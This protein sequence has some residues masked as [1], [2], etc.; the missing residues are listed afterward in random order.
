MALHQATDGR[1]YVLGESQYLYSRTDL[2][3]TIVYANKAFV[4]ASG[5]SIDEL[6]GAPHN[7]V[8]HPDMPGI[9]FADFW[10]T[11]RAGRTWV[12]LVKNRRKNGGFYWVRA[13]VSPVFDAGRCIGFAS[14]RVKP[15]I[16]EISQAARGYAAIQRGARIKVRDGGFTRPG[17]LGWLMRWRR[18]SLS[19]SLTLPLA[20]TMLLLLTLLGVASQQQHP[21]WGVF[22][23]LCAAIA[24]VACA[25]WRVE[26]RVLSGLRQLREMSIRLAAG[27]LLV[28]FGS[29]GDDELGRLFAAQAL[30]AK[31]QIN[32]LEGVHSASATLHGRCETV[33][34]GSRELEHRTQEEL[35]SMRQ[36]SA[37]LDRLTE[38]VELNAERA[39]QAHDLVEQASTTVERGGRD[40]ER[41]VTTM[42]EVRASSRQISEIVGMIDSIAFQ[43]NLLALN[44]SVEA[45]R[46]GEQGRGFAVVAGEVRALANKSADAARRVASLVEDTRTKIDGGSQEAAAAGETMRAIVDSTQRVNRIIAEISS[47]SKEQSEGITQVG[48]A[49]RSVDSAVQQNVALVERLGISGRELKSEADALDATIA[50]FRAGARQNGRRL[51]R[52]LGAG[53]GAVAT[54]D[55]V[56]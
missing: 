44:A 39:R 36:T 4:E 53:T 7:I 22:A 9:A 40:I 51:T 24:L 19:K 30:Q 27:D 54:T 35:V 11:L 26:R 14:I 23:V 29:R 55:M 18:P 3:G 15:S 1:E 33:S 34:T 47:V 12:G 52:G 38:A 31:S 50:G 2:D 20:G 5:Y 28:E 56:H 42:D 48:D 46:A 25:I 6:Y 17:V 8:R 10:R 45:A 43:T 13:Y 49:M 16:E 41:M 21:S 37:S 32:L